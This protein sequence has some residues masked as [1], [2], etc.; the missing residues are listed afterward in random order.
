MTK[1]NVL[2]I[3]LRISTNFI[4]KRPNNLSVYA[5]DVS[6]TMSAIR[7]ITSTNFMFYHATTL[8]LLSVF[9][10][11]SSRRTKYHS[12]IILLSSTFACISYLKY[13]TQGKNLFSEKEKNRIFSMLLVEFLKFCERSSLLLKWIFRLPV[14]ACE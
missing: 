7:A 14:H 1:F 8:E 10:T 9:Y 3:I 12:D 13:C 5:K 4:D 11:I 2:N 6:S